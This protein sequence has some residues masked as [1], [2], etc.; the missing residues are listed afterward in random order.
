MSR[1]AGENPLRSLGPLESTVM[2]AL[3]QSPTPVTVREMLQLLA[4]RELAYTTVMTVLDN[5]HRKGWV[6]RELDGRAY[7]YRPRSSREEHIGRLMT[8]ALS[9][10]ADQHAALARFVANMSAQEAAALRAILDQRDKSTA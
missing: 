3:W 10:A 6:E 2:N 9:S 8:E 1:R 5:L 7:R 4:D